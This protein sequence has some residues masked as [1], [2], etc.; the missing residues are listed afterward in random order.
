M[1]ISGG[2]WT[3]VSASVTIQDPWKTISFFGASILTALGGVLISWV[4][5]SGTAKKEATAEMQT[6]ISAV[7]QNLSQATSAISQAL[8]HVGSGRLSSETA[9]ALVEQD[10]QTITGQISQLQILVGEKLDASP[11]VETH[12]TVIGIASRLANLAREDTPVAKAELSAISVTLTGVG[13]RLQATEAKVVGKA[14][15]RDWKAPARPVDVRCPNCDASNSIVLTDRPGSTKQVSCLACEHSFNVHRTG[16]GEII[17][18]LVSRPGLGA[19]EPD[20][21]LVLNCGACGEPLTLAYKGEQDVSKRTVICVQCGGAHVV[22]LDT[23]EIK[24]LGM[25][26]KS[27]GEVLQW[28]GNQP[29]TSC[30]RCERLMRCS[31]RSGDDFYAFCKSDKQL[32][33]IPAV[34]F[35]LYKQEHKRDN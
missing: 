28:T 16:L 27:A 30:P 13:E 4:S 19:D 18:R 21:E 17:T 24:L 34:A 33:H 5:A 26:E 31:V 10:A 1:V 11:L 3:A 9:L 12:Q 22:R 2:L 7:S 15:I 29:W 6:H 32:V 25:Y 14:T 20:R 8:E 35:A 23:R